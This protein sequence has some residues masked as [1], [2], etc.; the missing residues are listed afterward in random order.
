[1]DPEE[2][3]SFPETLERL[4][5]EIEEG[6]F[7]R[8][9]QVCVSVG[10]EVVL[11][12]ALGEDG[13]GR[14]MRVDT[15]FRVYCTIKPVTALAVANLV[16]AGLIDLDQ[17]LSETLPSV[18]AVRGG[19]TARHI[20]NHTAGLHLMSGVT[21][22]MVPPD[23]RDAF[24][25]RQQRAPGWKVGLDAGYSEIFGWSLLGRLIET[26][27][28]EPLRVHLRQS[29]LDP[30]GMFQTSI[31]LDAAD[32]AAERDRLGVNVDLRG[33]R[34]FPLLFER[35][36]RV[37]CETNCA[38]GGYT[39]AEDLD[40]LYRALL[41]RLAGEDVA[42][43]P[44]QRT[45][46]EFT[47]AARPRTFD[48]VLDRECDYGLGFM[49]DL[50]DHRFGSECSPRSFGHSGNV[51]SS[52]AFAD[53]ERELSV[54]VVFNGIVDPDSSFFRRPALTRA[55]Y[56]DLALDREPEP[57]EAPK[58]GGLFRRRKSA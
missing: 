37:R 53:P 18:E 48:V 44:R 47:S 1:M 4:E 31:G 25:D 32:F 14:P 7:T 11:D 52:Y 6:L 21:L 20:L 46:E 41:R 8:G 17:P 40:R 9:A 58:R 56:A 28:E 10:D 35:T 39:T 26:I 16:D 43:L 34:A 51:G 33:W 13:L 50:E 55:I 38:H 5:A 15:L 12:I 24:F 23:K 3:S 45:L 2:M 49:T 29:V 36:E 54:A 57:A 42:G 30:L 22:E 27:T 19:V